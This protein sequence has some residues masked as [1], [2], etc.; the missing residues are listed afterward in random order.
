MN[1]L[2]A[3]RYIPKLVVLVPAYNEARAIVGVLDRVSAYA[4]MLIIIDDCS[5]D[6]TFQLVTKWGEDRSGFYLICLPQNTGASGALKA[7]YILVK[8]LLNKGIIAP[9]DLILEIDAD[10]QHDPKY[11]P[12]LRQQFLD[13]DNVDVVLA[14][15]IFSV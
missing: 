5:K 3:P 7:G 1:T 6:S 13:Y 4:D 14:R 9:D 10:G 11:I 15:R 12:Q 2:P 8:H